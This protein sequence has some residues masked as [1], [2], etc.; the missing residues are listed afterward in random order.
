VF[1]AREQKSVKERIPPLEN[2]PFIASGLG[3]GDVLRELALWAIAQLELYG[4]T[5]FERSKAVAL[6][7]AIVDEHV[8]VALYADKTKTLG[9]VEPFDGT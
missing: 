7:L 8:S 2:P 9:I 5:F 3:A 6:N 4:L 1:S